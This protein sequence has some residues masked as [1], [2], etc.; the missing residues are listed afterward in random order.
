MNL[1]IAEAEFENE[2]MY[3]KEEST[4]SEFELQMNNVTQRYIFYNF[5]YNKS[6]FVNTKIQLNIHQTKLLF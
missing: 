5:V 3:T 6:T 2:I 1:V 4:Y